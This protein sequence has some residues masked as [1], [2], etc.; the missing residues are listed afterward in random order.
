[1]GILQ[2][3]GYLQQRHGIPPELVQTLQWQRLS[4]QSDGVIAKNFRA[5]RLSGCERFVRSSGSGVPAREFAFLPALHSF[6][7]N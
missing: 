2:Q 4:C 5:P 1:V 3:P 6:L 7:G